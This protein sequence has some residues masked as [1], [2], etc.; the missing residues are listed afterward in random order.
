VLSSDKYCKVCVSNK[1]GGFHSAEDSYCGILVTPGG[2][3]G[4]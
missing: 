2:L 1:L 3:V 4:M